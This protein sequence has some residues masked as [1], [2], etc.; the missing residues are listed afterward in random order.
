MT[1]LLLLAAISLYIVNS[2]QAKCDESG[3]NCT[4][5]CRKKTFETPILYELNDIISN[6]QS[7]VTQQSSVSAVKCAHSMAHYGPYKYNCSR[8]PYPPDPGFI[9]G[10]NKN[11]DDYNAFIC[12][13]TNNNLTNLPINT[14]IHGLGAGGNSLEGD[15]RGLFETW[16]SWGIVTVAPESCV[17][18]GCDNLFYDQETAILQAQ[19]NQS[20][21]PIFE[22]VN[23]TK[24]AISGH[25]MGGF[26][27]M[28]TAGPW[29][30]NSMYNNFTAKCAV[31]LHPGIVCPGCQCNDMMSIP[32]MWTTG[33]QDNIVNDK[34]V[35]DCYNKEISTKP[36]VI[37]DL[38]GATHF[39]PNDKD[40]GHL[41]PYMAQWILCMTNNDKNACDYIYGNNQTSLCNACQYKTCTFSI[42]D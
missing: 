8:T 28:E 9:C 25:S 30:S 3:L 15:Y 5:A 29:M 11:D 10:E 2:Q 12:Y 17:N 32:S 27:T 41:A 4:E 24:V 23:F 33:T 40:G 18:W 16:A 34:S 42:D 35:I 39:E 26:T 1:A 38:I 21:H 13:P 20:I 36:K 31:L 19:N 14:F 6:K 22:K 37:A 7:S